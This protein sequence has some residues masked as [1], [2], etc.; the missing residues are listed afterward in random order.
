MNFG[1]N[2]PKNIILMFLL[3]DGNCVISADAEKGEKNMNNFKY[4]WQNI[5][6]SKD[7]INRALFDYAYNSVKLEKYE[8]DLLN[9]L[10]QKI[11][12]ITKNFMCYQICFLHQ[13][14]TKAA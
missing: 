8:I 5:A 11:Y 2:I 12:Y 6:A 3:N 7:E 13:E 1:K 4:N 10:S 14:L 9:E